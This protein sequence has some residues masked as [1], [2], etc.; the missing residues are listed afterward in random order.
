MAVV[1]CDG[2]PV[3]IHA[4]N[5]ELIASRWHELWPEF[6][7]VITELI[8]S[9]GAKGLQWSLELGAGSV[10]ALTVR[11]RAKMFSFS[12]RVRVRG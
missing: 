8:R 3:G 2:Q 11:C 6:R 12:A 1:T 10:E 7:Q 4:K 9:H 5:F